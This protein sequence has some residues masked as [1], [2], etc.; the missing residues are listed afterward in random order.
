MQEGCQAFSAQHVRGVLR[1]ALFNADACF[2][3]SAFCFLLLPL[4]WQQGTT[5]AS[6]RL[7]PQPWPIVSTNVR[8]EVCHDEDVRMRVDHLAS[9]IDGGIFPNNTNTIQESDIYLL[10]VHAST[11]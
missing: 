8:R 5:G 9:W 7:L 11:G 2:L 1:G 4:T 6:I 10:E 3:L